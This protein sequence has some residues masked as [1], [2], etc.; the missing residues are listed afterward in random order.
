MS[1]LR[2][3]L[4]V[5]P[6]C[7]RALSDVAKVQ[8][9]VPSATDQANPIAGYEY[10][11]TESHPVGSTD[12]FPTA[13]PATT[14]IHVVTGE[15]VKFPYF[16]CKDACY[17]PNVTINDLVEVIPADSEKGP[18]DIW[19]DGFE[20]PDLPKKAGEVYKIKGT[21]IGE[22]GP[23]ADMWRYKYD[24]PAVDEAYYFWRKYGTIRTDSLPEDQFDAMWTHFFNNPLIDRFELRRGCNIIHDMDLIPEPTLVEEMF[25][26]CRRINDYPMTI[27]ILEGIKDKIPFDPVVY[28]WMVQELTPVMNEL[29]IK[30]PDELGLHIAPEGKGPLPY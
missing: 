27:R 6:L 21:A 18:I 8:S 3:L 16:H 23:T 10:I 19:L 4:N 22:T 7:V 28:K 11:R 1:A 29:G 12:S 15:E 2:R 9:V 14:G 30:T 26:A 17:D 24:I 25:R 20:F 13:P 5:R